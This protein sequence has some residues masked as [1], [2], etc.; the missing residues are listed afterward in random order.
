MDNTKLNV[1]NFVKPY[2]KTHEG[3]RKEH[4]KWIRI[5]QYDLI[6]I[7]YE[8]YSPDPLELN[9]YWFHRFGFVYEKDSNAFK[10][11][12][13]TGEIIFTPR[14]KGFMLNSTDSL[15]TIYYVHELQNLMFCL[16]GKELIE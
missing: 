12:T 9:S 8:G 16:T 13:K 10:F 1:G 11:E 3:V 7:L 14:K 5:T 2:R 6:D 4:L 15:T